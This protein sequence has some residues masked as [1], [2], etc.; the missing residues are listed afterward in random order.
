M[1]MAKPGGVWNDL[2]AKKKEIGEKREKTHENR[3][4]SIKNTFP[5]N[6]GELRRT[7]MNSAKK[8]TPNEKFV[9]KI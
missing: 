6:S 3:K 9:R 4:T 2:V 1:R 5:T 7:P 8:N